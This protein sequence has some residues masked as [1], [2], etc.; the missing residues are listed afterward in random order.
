[1]RYLRPRACSLS[2]ARSSTI[3]V[4]YSTKC[5]GAAIPP[6]A[7]ITTPAS[8]TT[9]AR[10]NRQPQPVLFCNFSNQDRAVAN[11]ETTQLRMHTFAQ[12]LANDVFVSGL[13]HPAHQ[14]FP[15]V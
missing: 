15:I 10:R 8:N 9:K 13:V 5:A 14:L 7:S 3:R 6:F 12:L 2:F 1:M 11:F 4:S